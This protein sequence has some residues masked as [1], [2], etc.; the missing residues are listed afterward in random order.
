MTDES[1]ANDVVRRPAHVTELPLLPQQ[2]RWLT[3]EDR[4]PGASTPLVQL[5]Y[6]LRGPLDLDAW[7]DAVSAV[8]D[9]H[10]ALRAR[11][12]TRD[13]VPYQ[14]F[15]PPA[16]LDMEYLDLS[17]L[18]SDQ[19]ETHARE[20]MVARMKVRFNYATGPLAAST[21]VHIA[22]DDHVWMLTIAHIVAD[23]A[24][25]VTVIADLATAY[26]ALLQGCPPDLPE[27]DIRYGDYLAWYAAQDPARYD[28]DL[29]YWLDRLD[30]APSFEP[31]LDHPRPERKG[32]PAG[33][34]RHSVPGEHYRAAATWAQHHRSSRYVVMLTFVQATLHRWTGQTDFCIGLPVAGSERNHP[35]FQHIVGLFNRMVALRCDLTGDPTFTQLLRRTREAL[36]DA[37]EHQ[38][39]AFSKVVAAMGVPNDPSRAQLC[40]VV[41]LVNEFQDSGDLKLTGLTVADF[42]LTVPG[43]PYDLMICGVPADDG[44]ALRTFYDTG[45][46]TETSVSAA[47]DEFDRILHFAATHPESHLSEVD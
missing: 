22:A 39:L 24:S 3:I 6:R 34:V 28:E 43:M 2:K 14:W 19:R 4:H 5:V 17:D 20:L 38:D 1:P 12:A 21:M 9:R 30:G 8:V 37:L 33:E 23:G 26:N 27:I 42:P 11:F 18:P 40:Q 44:L 25:L 47:L 41:F 10:E 35:R 46:F 45:L 7:R 31:P 15:A 16:G 36:L 32:A 29:A 13:G